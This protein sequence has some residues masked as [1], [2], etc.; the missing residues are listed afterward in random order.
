MQADEL[1]LPDRLARQIDAGGPISVAHYM[2]EANAHYYNSR[3]PLGAGGDFITAPEISQMFGELIG[4]WL[5]DLWMRSGRK[6]D[7]LYVEL[8]PGRGTLAVDALRAMEMAALAPKVHLVET[9]EALR[10]KQK[11][12]ISHA[13][14]HDDL[15][16][17]PT[18]GPILAVANEFFDALP[19][20]QMVATPKGW[21]E[22]VV[23]RALNG[24]PGLFEPMAGFR[25]MDSA[26]PD[27]LRY[28]PEGAILESSP[29]S[30]TVAYALA[31]RIARQGGAAII[32]D[33]GYEGPAL[34]DTLQAVRGHMASNPFADP[35]ASDL[36]AHVDFT[37][38]GNM[39]RQAGLK[40]F[41]PVGQGAWLKAV[42]ID[43]RAA[44]LA[45]KSPE[46]AEEIENARS[47]LTA[48]DQMGTLFKAMAF[49][50]PD[51]A[52]AEGF[53]G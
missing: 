6:A 42:G 38:L 40:V 18:S 39:A 10:A 45:Q 30:A 46:R 49:V 25:P 47:R 22:R 16:S 15:D 28:V 19:V 29:A 21:R 8:G 51:W 52:S 3:D 41:G 36:T 1:P 53:N 11:A 44:M 33:Y 26:V 20:R 43:A 27:A 35:G 32:I 31:L 12:N 48:D 50:H 4:L 34:G 14:W 24:E 23:I 9:S 17:L 5:A 13:D 7:P 37:C 2:A